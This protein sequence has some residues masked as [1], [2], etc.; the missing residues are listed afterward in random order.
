MEGLYLGHIYTTFL[1]PLVFFHQLQSL[2]VVHQ[3]PCV[4]AFQ[5]ALPFYKILQLSFPP[6]TSVAFD[7]LNFVLFLIV[8]KV[9]WGP[10]VVLPVFF[11]LH[12]GG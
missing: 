5:I 12:I 7:G 11:C 2:Y 9:R 8:N 4:V 6:M 1:M 10:Q 3:L